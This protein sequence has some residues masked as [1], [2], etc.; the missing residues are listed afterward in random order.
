MI[1]I[2]QEHS[3]AKVDEILAESQNTSLGEKES[4]ATL[5]EDAGAPQRKTGAWVRDGKG[6]IWRIKGTELD[7]VNRTRTISLEGILATLKDRIIPNEK[8]AAD[9]GGGET[10]TCTQ[11]IRHILSYQS[12]WTLGGCDFS[13]A[14]PYKFSGENLFTALQTVT[15]TL[16]GAYWDT[17]TSSYPFKLYIK[18][19]NWTPTCEMRMGRNIQSLRYSTDL[20]RTYT[21]FYPVGKDDLRIGYVSRNESEYGIREATGTDTAK[22]TE[23]ELRQWANQMLRRHAEPAVTASINGLDLSESTGEPLD[24]LGINR[25]CQ[26][27]LPEYGTTILLRITRLQYPDEIRE[28]E[29]VNVTMANELGDVRSIARA[30]NEQS[31]SM[32]RGGRGGA[33]QQKED[34]AWFVDTE[35]HVAMVAEAIVGD[36]GTGKPD[37]SRVSQIVVDGEGIHQR[38]TKTEN[39]IVTAESAILAN[40]REIA[41]RVR[42]GD[43]ATQL[44]VEAGNVRIQN[45]NLIVDGIV[46]AEAVQTAIASIAELNVRMITSE[47][48]GIKVSTVSTNTFKQGDVDCYVPNAVHDVQ[49]VPSGNQ[50]LLQRKRFSGGDTWTTVSTFKRVT[51]LT[52]GWSGGIYTVNATGDSS[53]TKQT[54]ITTIDGPRSITSNGTYTYKVMYEN[55]SGQ[56]ADTGYPGAEVTVNISHNPGLDVTA[57][58]TGSISGRTSKGSYTASSMRNTYMLFDVSCGGRT[59]RYYITFN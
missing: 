37:W 32:A 56:D 33:R 26:A 13:T 42:K 24:R 20:S 27:P 31:E 59:N 8:T 58:W 1:S 46:T 35:D 16:D 12:D 39:D 41:L 38:V 48:G 21:R 9:M 36:D 45:G 11:A 25:I 7:P 53:L 57:G 10:C 17:D 29:R 3:L 19:I 43:V 28:P 49:I 55:D 50:Y 52:G 54:T 23:A 51:A 34:H 4:T 18:R 22:E 15:D 40:E 30:I 2:L 5:T 44:T 6:R 14:L 47:R